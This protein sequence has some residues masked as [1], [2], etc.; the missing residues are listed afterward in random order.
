MEGSSTIGCLST[1]FHCTST[2]EGGHVSEAHEAE[3][4]AGFAVGAL[5]PMD[6]YAH[7]RLNSDISFGRKWLLDENEALLLASFREPHR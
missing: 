3:V 6:D 4:Q 1:H 2:I 7:W 5:Q